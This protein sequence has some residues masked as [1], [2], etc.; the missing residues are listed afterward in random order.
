MYVSSLRKFNLTSDTSS[1]FK[2]NFIPSLI[3]QHKKILGIVIAA[4]CFIA[5]GWAIHRFCI[6]SKNLSDKTSGGKTS[7]GNGIGGKL[8]D[9][10][11]GIFSNIVTKTLP[12]GDVYKGEIKDDKYHG[13]GKLT[14]KNYTY[15]GEFKDDKYH[16]KGKLT[17]KEYNYEGQFNEGKA[18]GEGK[19]TLKMGDIYEGTFVNYRIIKGTLKS[20]N[21]DHY[22]GEFKDN[23][24]HGKGK[25]IVSGGKVYE[26]T[27]RNGLP[28]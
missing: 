7:G 13:K 1:L 25:L 20:A 6:K 8:G 18:E 26:G 11:G 22:E 24:Y 23:K 9:I 21:G 15:E 3:F 17:F 14:T 16:G 2:N 27:F 5:A 10:L 19:L 28:V 4:L 12:N